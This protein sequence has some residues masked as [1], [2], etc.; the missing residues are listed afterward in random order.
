RPGACS[1]AARPPALYFFTQ[2][3][4]VVCGIPSSA[5][6]RAPGSLRSTTAL[7]AD[8][9][10]SNGQAE[11]RFLPATSTR[12]C[13]GRSASELTRLLLSGFYVCPIGG[14]VLSSF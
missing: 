11:P 12:P 1:S 14:Q 2:S 13:G 3:A 8:S 4:T 7:A 9:T 5:A 6:T 10:T